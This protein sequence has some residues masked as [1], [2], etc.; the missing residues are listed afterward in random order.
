MDVW[1]LSRSM[2]NTKVLSVMIEKTWNVTHLA[3]RFLYSSLNCIH[4]KYEEFDWS[5][6]INNIQPNLDEQNRSHGR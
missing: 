5:Y 6:Q 1:T 3:P 2:Q 4:Y